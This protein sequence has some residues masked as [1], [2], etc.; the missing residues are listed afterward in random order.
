MG[1]TS[2]RG[3]QVVVDGKTRYEN[4]NFNRV[5]TMKELKNPW[6]R[7]CRK[8]ALHEETMGL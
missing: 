1:V 3:L 4:R 8:N 2:L 6:K 7:K 5:K